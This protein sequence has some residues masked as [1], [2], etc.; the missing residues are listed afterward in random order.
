MAAQFHVASAD[1]ALVSTFQQEFGLPRFVAR[2]MA[3]HGIASVGEA[4][5]FLAPDLERDWRNPY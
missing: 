3:A 1:P 2:T 5:S 4:R